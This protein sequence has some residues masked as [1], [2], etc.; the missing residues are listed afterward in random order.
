MK[1]LW[2]GSGWKMTKTLAEGLSYAERL[3][4]QLSVPSSCRVFVAAP[5]THLWGLRA[6]LR[7]TPILLGAQNMHWEDE[8][9]YTGEISPRMLA[10]IGVDFV[11]LG[12]SERRAAFGETDLMVNRKVRAALA[13]RIVPLVCIGETGEERDRGQADEVVARQV[14]FALEGVSRVDPGQLW[15]ACEPVWAIGSAGTAATPDVAGGAHAVIRSVLDERFGRSTAGEIPILYGGSVDR[16]N[17]AALVMQAQV[18]GLFVGRS[19]WEV[20]SFLEIIRLAVQAASG[21]PGPLAI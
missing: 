3:S 15:I 7:D 17:A 16:S 1:S 5:F 6:A 20:S 2:L 8:G 18:D 19:A 4:C 9:P 12:H 11:E 10:E 13:K 14:R 21:A